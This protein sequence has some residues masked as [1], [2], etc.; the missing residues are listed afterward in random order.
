MS[1]GSTPW[2]DHRRS[3]VWLVTI[4]ISWHAPLPLWAS[5]WIRC[6]ARKETKSKML[7]FFFAYSFPLNIRVFNFSSSISAKFRP[8]YMPTPLAL[9]TRMGLQNGGGGGG[10]WAHFRP[11]PKG[12]WFSQVQTQ[13]HVN[14]TVNGDV[15]FGKNCRRLVNLWKGQ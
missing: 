9:D 2:V 4:Y 1:I 10:M 12:G 7:L 13:H 6:S 3:S 5:N 11:N 15:Q 8:L 14:F